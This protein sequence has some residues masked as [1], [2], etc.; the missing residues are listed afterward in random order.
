MINAP[1]IADTITP[2]ST[3]ETGSSHPRRWARP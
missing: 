2:T 3:S 1:Q